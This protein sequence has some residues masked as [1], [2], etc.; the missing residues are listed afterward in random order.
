M[1]CSPRMRSA[2]AGSRWWAGSAIPSMRR[3]RASKRISPPSIRGYPRDGSPLSGGGT[4]THGYG[5]RAPPCWRSFDRGDL[6]VMRH[7]AAG[8][9]VLTFPRL[10]QLFGNGACMPAAGIPPL[11]TEPEF[12][13]VSRRNDSL[14]TRWRWRFLGSLCVVRQHHHRAEVVPFGDELPTEERPAVAR[15]LRRALAVR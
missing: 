7:F 10:L 3:W 2:P 1:R 9:S 11:P 6:M 12:C 5:A 8:P 14:G 4:R 15:E 13:V